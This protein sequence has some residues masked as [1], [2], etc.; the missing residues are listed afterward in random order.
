MIDTRYKLGIYNYV[1]GSFIFLVF[2]LL[3]SWHVSWDQV[4]KFGQ[5]N[6][7]GFCNF[8]TIEEL[9]DLDI[10]ISLLFF[11]RKQSSY[12]DMHLA[13]FLLHCFQVFVDLV[14]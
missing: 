10:N 3:P 9:I 4:L 1:I 6:L 8:A 12:E 2:L 7:I 14:L 13:I 5:F 11:F